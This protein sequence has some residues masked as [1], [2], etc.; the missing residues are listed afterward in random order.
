MKRF[1][2]VL[3]CISMLL[4]L[5]AVWAEETEILPGLSENLDE[6]W[7]R[8][9]ATQEEMDVML[10]EWREWYT[11]S[12]WEIPWELRKSVEW[13]LISKDDTAEEILE[14][15]LKGYKPDFQNGYFASSVN[16]EFKYVKQ[17][18]NANCFEYL[19]NENSY[20][21]VP[22]HFDYAAIWTFNINKN[23]IRGSFPQDDWQALIIQYDS[24][25]WLNNKENISKE[26]REMDEVGINDMC[27]I[28][29]RDSFVLLYIDG[30]K[31][32]Y[33]IRLQST[34]SV[35]DNDLYITFPEIEEHKLYRFSDV[36]EIIANIELI[37]GKV[38]KGKYIVQNIVA[39]KEVFEDEAIALQEDGLL[40][41]NE[42]GLDLLKP[43]TRIEAAAMLLRAMGE[44]ETAPDSGAQTFSDVSQS[45][46]G[47]GAAERAASVG[48]IRGIGDGQFAPDRTVAATEFATMVLRAAKAGEFDW[49][50]ALNILIEDEVLNQEDTRGM[51]FFTRGDMAKI[52]YEARVKGLL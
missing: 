9:H 42:K 51:D 30:V 8:N 11:A 7:L 15:R 25:E 22:Y 40:R 32:D 31:D 33:I 19:L 52:I 23:L 10:Q 38:F 18:V 48:L 49:A 3:I 16:I 46:W 21:A 5:T 24:I 26:L 43:L 29:T 45:H 36:V 50:Q 17:Y 4:S 2:M 13:R 47:Y 39:E 28:G 34:S 12:F 44:P 6:L 27:I 37:N 1:V 20:W 41:G 14:Q 35:T